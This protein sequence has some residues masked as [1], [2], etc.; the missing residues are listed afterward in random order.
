MVEIDLGGSA[1]LRR[2]REELEVLRL[3]VAALEQERDRWAARV[4]LLEGRID[5]AEK[6]PRGNERNEGGAP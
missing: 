1:A 4:R 3:Q 6:A 2:A 5:A